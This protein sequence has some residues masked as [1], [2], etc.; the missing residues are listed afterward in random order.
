MSGAANTAQAVA[1]EVVGKGV[2]A[3]SGTG[4]TGFA[5]DLPQRLPCHA[6][7]SDIMV[8]RFPSPD[9]SRPG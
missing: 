9:G 5:I 2:L 1:R 3:H 4:E 8:E 6:T 7:A